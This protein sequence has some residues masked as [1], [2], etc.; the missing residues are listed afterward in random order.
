MLLLTLLRADSMIMKNTEWTS[1]AV[2]PGNILA[3]RC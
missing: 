1:L 2:N 3:M